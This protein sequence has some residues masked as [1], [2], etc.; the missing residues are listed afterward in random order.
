MM[1]L[2]VDIAAVVAGPTGANLEHGVVGREMGSRSAPGVWCSSGRLGV[3]SGRFRTGGV[4]GVAAA[5]GRMRRGQG[6]SLPAG[7]I[8]V[9]DV[10]GCVRRRAAS[11]VDGLRVAALPRWRVR[12]TALAG[13]ALRLMVAV[14]L[15]GREPLVGLESV[16]H[17]NRKG[18]TSPLGFSPKA[19]TS[20]TTRFSS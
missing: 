5:T 9:L 17:N 13:R 18:Q 16:H 15:A 7:P 1:I 11:D 6:A 10:C 4:P 14:A 20:A 19:F 3:G 8:V 12:A 2:R